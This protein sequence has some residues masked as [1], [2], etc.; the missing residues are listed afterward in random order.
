M[1]L[2]IEWLRGLLLCL[3]SPGHSSSK[4][5][6]NTCSKWNIR[7]GVALANKLT[8]NT[9]FH[10]LCASF[11]RNPGES[12]SKGRLD[13]PFKGRPELDPSFEIRYRP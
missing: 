8:G 9:A 6:L 4:Y 10:A 7:R 2:H 3:S 11:V 1:A 13:K 5:I 12:S